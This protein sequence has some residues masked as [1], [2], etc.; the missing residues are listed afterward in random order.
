MWSVDGTEAAKSPLGSG[1]NTSW[2]TSL[3]FGSR[4]AASEIPGVGNVLINERPTC[5]SKEV[6]GCGTTTSNT[7]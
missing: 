4:V 1:E 6:T 5:A 2:V 3:V 7:M